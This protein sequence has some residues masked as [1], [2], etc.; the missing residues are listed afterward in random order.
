MLLYFG[1]R[2]RHQADYSNKKIVFYFLYSF[3][4]HLKLQGI[5]TTSIIAGYALVRFSGE[6]LQ[7]LPFPEV[8]ERFHLYSLPI[9]EGIIPYIFSCSPPGV[10]E[11]NSNFG[12]CTSRRCL[13]LF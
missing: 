8:L 13:L 9:P 6:L 12:F 10:V 7:L 4:V 5:D 1:S 3:C 2:G 11:R